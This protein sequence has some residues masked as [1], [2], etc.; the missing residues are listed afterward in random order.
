VVVGSLNPSICCLEQNKATYETSLSLHLSQLR[1][2]CL[3]YYETI[4]V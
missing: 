4:S 3:Y 2:T 1:S